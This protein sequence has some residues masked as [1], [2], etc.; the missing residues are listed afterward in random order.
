MALKA[1]PVS[2]L[3]NRESLGVL[4]RGK[5]RSWADITAGARRLAGALRAAGV[6]RGDHI[7]WLGE[8]CHRVV[9]AYFGVPG[10][11]AILVPLH[12]R[13][14]LAE[15]KTMVRATQPVLLLCSPDMQHVA[16]KLGVEQLEALGDDAADWSFDEDDAAATYFTSGSSGGPKRITF[17]H[18]QLYSHACALGEAFRLGTRAT[19]LLS[20][21]AWHCNAW[22]RIH[23]CAAAETRLVLQQRWKVAEALALIE[24][25]GVTE[26]NL[27]PAM[28]YDVLAHASH[29][30]SSVQRVQIGGASVCGTMVKRLRS[31]FPSAYV[32]E[33]YG[34]TEAAGAVLIDGRPLPGTCAR[35]EDE[36]LVRSDVTAGEWLRTGD[37]AHRDSDGRIRITGRRKDLIISGGENI[38]PAEVEQVLLDHPDVMECAVIGVPDER[39]GEVPEAVVVPV[40]G[41]AISSESLMRF[42]QN[43]LA[44]FKAPR[45]IILRQSPL[46]R[47]ATG[48]V[49]H[50]ALR[51]ERESE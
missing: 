12:A 2:L 4:C 19:E 41:S 20:I 39:L 6:R 23:L 21:P 38:S 16:R 47:T 34:L 43:R 5:W 33:G 9:E 50:T 11:G 28:A 7:A 3:K 14:S 13:C 45:R 25:H 27:V 44:R 32:F 35:I 51:K 29:A 40:E 22:G 17:T 15:L 48:K 42:V 24:Q 10:S 49:V 37:V 26:L 46:P 36:L 30:Y 31:V 1:S 8:N 18:R